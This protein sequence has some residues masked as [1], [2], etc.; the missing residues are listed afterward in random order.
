MLLAVLL[1]GGSPH[2]S[3][4][5]A[6]AP[7]PLR[8]LAGCWRME[9]RGTVI[10]EQW[11]APLGGM[12]LGQGRTVRNG[13]VVEYESVIVRGRDRWLLLRG[14]P[15]GPAAGG[16]SAL[17]GRRERMRSCLPI[18]STTFRNRSVTADSARIHFWHGSRGV[19]EGV[20]RRLEFPYT[21]V[22]C[23]AP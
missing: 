1:H 14:P 20:H 22:G 15:F 18:R 12:M 16:P 9:R 23:T 11:L 4:R 3:L 6:P 8:W 7:E 10:D 5:S 17:P 13:A 21:R 2:V 19:T